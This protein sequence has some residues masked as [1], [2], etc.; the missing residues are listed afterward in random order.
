[1]VTI[2]SY[3]DGE[4]AE[5]ALRGVKTLFMVSATESTDRVDQHRAFVDAAVRADVGHIVYTSFISAA[6]DAVF[7]F[8]RDHYAT[9]EHIKASPLGWTFLRDNFYLDFMPGF[10]GDDG[11]IRGPAADGRCAMVARADVARTA[12]A[13]LREPDEHHGKTYDITGPEAL[14]MTE[15][16]EILSSAEGRH[17]TFHNETIEEAYE[18]RRSYPAADWEYD[19]WVSTYTAIAAGQMS[20]LSG[21]V[22]AVTGQPPMSL[23]EY[24]AQ[25]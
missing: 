1:M 2:S 24:L 18:S 14:T 5:R 25:R 7:T 20:Q 12:A 13:I 3:G 17:I 8:A 4:S 10:V 16:A 22:E 6:P 9:E 19:A 11:V 21:D 23:A 15:V